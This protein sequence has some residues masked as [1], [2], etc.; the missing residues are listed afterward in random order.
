MIKQAAM[1][2]YIEQLLVETSDTTL[3][4]VV[5]NILDEPIPEAVK[6]RL[7]KPF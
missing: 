2:E 4:D 6:E 3:H 1:N 5:E 7:L